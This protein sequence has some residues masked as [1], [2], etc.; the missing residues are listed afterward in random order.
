MSTQYDGIKTSYGSMEDLPAREVEK[1]SVERVLGDVTGQRCLDLACGLGRWSRYLIDKGAAHVVGIDISQGMI[2]SAQAAQR[3]LPDDPAS[4]TKLSFHIADLSKPFTAPEGPFDLA[5][6]AWFLNYAAT[7]R[8][9]VAM[10]RTARDNLR[11]GG[12]F[13]GI[14]CNT[15]CPMFEPFDDR[16][17]VA[18][19]AVETTRDGW[20]CRLTARTHPEPVEFEFFYMLHDKYERAAEEAG[21]ERVRWHGYVLPEDG[22]KEEGFWDVYMLRPHFNIVSC[23]RPA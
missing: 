18:V 16:Y 2:A 19:E 12:R 17:G 10:F 11:P 4:R 14:T 22:R 21:L 9:L 20:R 15:H 23:F 3:A 1:P 7:Y 6:G 8:D 13:V 5:F